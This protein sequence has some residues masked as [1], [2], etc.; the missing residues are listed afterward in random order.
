M[1]YSVDTSAILNNWHRYYPPDVFPALWSRLDELIEAG[2]L[3]ATEEVLRELQ[4]QS[5]EVYAW[6]T[7]RKGMFQPLDGKIQI[8]VRDI[9]HGFPRLVDTRKHRSGADPFVIALA[10]VENGGVITGEQPSGVLDK[11]H[12]PDVCSALSIPCMNLLDLIRMQGW[13]FR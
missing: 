4:R 3:I 6:A 10:R 2:M 9:L 7:K 11:P 8:V 1:K 13:V 5:D 12:I